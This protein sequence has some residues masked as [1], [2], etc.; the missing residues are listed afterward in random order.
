MEAI[1]SFLIL[2]SAYFLG[3]LALVQ[4]GVRPIRKLV[5]DPNTQRK[6]FISNHLKIIVLSLILALATTSVYYWLFL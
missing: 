3:F 2:F 6:V 4:L 1:V 5:L